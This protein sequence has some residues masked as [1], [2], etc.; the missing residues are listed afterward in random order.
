MPERHHRHNPSAPLRLLQISDCHLHAEPHSVWKGV[1]TEATL[2]RVLEHIAQVRPEADQVLATGDLAHDASTAAYRR[3]RGHLLGL[4]RPVHCLPGNHDDPAELGRV[5]AGGDIRIDKSARTQ[6]WH[7]LLLDTSLTGSTAGRL[8]EDELAFLQS[9][10]ANRPT[11]PTLVAL[12][13]H[14]L[15]IGSEWLDALGLENPERLFEI[16]DRHPQVRV[17]VF[18]HIHAPVDA[19]RGGVRYLGAPSTCVQ[20]DHRAGVSRIDPAPPAYRWLRLWADGR[21]ET[22]L[23]WVN[24]GAC[25]DRDRATISPLQWAGEA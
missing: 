20:F 4:G 12:H 15:P 18:G 9:A 21:T 6:G 7:L 5:L 14:P 23:E 3:L 1:D 8:G 25:S 10:L 17:V 22:G 16:L 19:T 24:T 13:H 2:L 11:L